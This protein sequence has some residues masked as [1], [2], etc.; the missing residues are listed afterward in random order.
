MRVGN[1]LRNGKCF[2]VP[3]LTGLYSGGVRRA[4]SSYPRFRRFFIAAG[5]AAIVQPAFARTSE[6]SALDTSAGGNAKKPTQN[7]TYGM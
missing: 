6:G 5:C 3:A 1:V 4:F 7:N 2:E